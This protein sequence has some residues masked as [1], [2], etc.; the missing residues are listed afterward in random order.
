MLT[1]MAGERKGG[2]G[3]QEAASKGLGLLTATTIARSISFQEEGG[4]S[5]SK[6]LKLAQN[7]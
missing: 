2:K 5:I 3:E 6:A 4:P 7:V 1:G